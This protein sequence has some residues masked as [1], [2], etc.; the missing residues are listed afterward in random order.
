MLDGDPGPERVAENRDALVSGRGPDG[1]HVIRPS[2]Q[3]DLPRA[4]RST[5]A[6]QVEVDDRGVIGEAVHPRLKVGVIKA[7]GA[8]HQDQR[9]ARSH[10]SPEQTVHR[11]THQA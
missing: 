7:H 6:R 5:A 11:L 10:G 1:I 8:V 4:L 3:G 9:R 2:L